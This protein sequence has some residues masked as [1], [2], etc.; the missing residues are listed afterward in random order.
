[1][2]YT[3]KVALVSGGTR[4]IG[5]NVSKSLIEKG[6]FCY[7][8]GRNKEDG[9]NAQEEL[10]SN[11][12]YVQLDVTNE[13]AVIELFDLIRKEHG[14]LDLAVN[15]A[16]IT[17]KRASVQELD[18]NEWNRVLQVNLVGP[19]LLMSHQIRLMA[20]GE[21]GS[22]VN[23][24]SCGGVLGQPR[25]SAYSTSKAALNMLT[26]V[27]AVESANPPEGKS[28]VRI[29]AVCPGPTLGGMNTEERLRANPASTEEKIQSTAMKRFAEPEEITAAILWLL[30][31][32]SSYVTGTLLSV[33]GG[34]S[35]GKF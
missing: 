11:S 8:T 20:L 34:F 24:S 9:L 29:N 3:G 4:G 1:M 15:N 23:V 16:G 18:L 25:Q 31:E 6:V 5:F 14:R 10:G 2:S 30:S 13:R 22:I 7:I 28:V 32:Q 26:Q 27:A 33:D 19:L 35:A 12:R 17:T 21:K